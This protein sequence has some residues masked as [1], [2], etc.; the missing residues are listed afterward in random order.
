MEWQFRRCANEQERQQAERDGWQS[1]GY[2]RL[3]C[4]IPPPRG[5][6]FTTQQCD[7]HSVVC[8]A[9]IA[10]RVVLHTFVSDIQFSDGGWLA[11]FSADMRWALTSYQCDHDKCHAPALQRLLPN[12][13]G[14]YLFKDDCIW[15]CETRH[16][17]EHI[18]LRR[19]N[20][21]G[22]RRTRVTFTPNGRALLIE[23]PN[24]ARCV[25]HR[26]FP[27]TEKAALATMP[28]EIWQALWWRDG[29]HAIWARVLSF[30]E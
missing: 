11:I 16:H 19:V 24:D 25:E 15:G 28:S 20:A 30:A 8:A 6:S 21:K 12:G 3:Y 18:V 2:P 22:R 14:R 29:D 9:S 23:Q 5:F 17:T 26:L 7:A 4:A 13:Y 27:I 1:V 10:G